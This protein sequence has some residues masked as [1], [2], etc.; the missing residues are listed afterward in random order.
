ML[1]NF[2]FTAA[3][4]AAVMVMPLSVDAQDV[5]SALARMDAIIKQMEQLRTEF[6]A[7][8]A[9]LGSAPTPSAVPT[10]LGAQ[11]K[12]YLTQD[13]SYGVTNSDIERIQRLLATD[14]EIYPYGVASGFFGPKTE[15]AIKNFQARFGLDTVGA[16]G[17][18]TTALLE[19]FFNAYPDENYP[20]GVLAKKP[21]VLGVSTTVTPSPTPTPAVVSGTNPAK[22]INVTLDDGEA[23]IEIIYT[24][25]N[26]KGLVT[27]TDDEDEV[28]DYIAAK[29]VL[30][31]DQVSAVIDFDGSS[32]SRDDDNEDEG[33]EDEADEALDDAE[34]E[35]DDAE[36]AINEA[37]DDDED[38]DWAEETL[39]EAYD[40]FD[41]A[42]DAFDDEDYSKATKLAKQAKALAKKAQDRVGEEEDDSSEKGDTDDIDKI[43]AEIDED[44]SHITVEYGDGD[45]YE[46][47]VEEDKENNIIEEVAD[48]LNLDED[49]VEDL[50]EFDYGR[51]D[52]IDALIEDDRSLVY[53]YYK[54]GVSKR[55]VLDE[56][57][58]DDIIKEIADQIDEDEDDVED[59]T[60]FDY[61]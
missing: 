14:S 32:S 45:D 55:L 28:I 25:G 37:E 8:S 16:I 29:T 2:V 11:T 12:K 48:E 26:R 30:T 54:S 61:K 6:V 46:F 35:L 20:T 22:E 13:L 49:D 52:Y 51:V 18:A 41:D 10:V 59:W 44:E 7:L 19:V 3:L 15:E 36:E 56:T 9:S 57:D 27:D 40:T 42:E 50:I 53:V 38:T 60:E 33:D 24:N 43:V 1:K 58:E 17:P 47:D 23:L 4:F 5:S 21:A 39:D 31:K 34:D